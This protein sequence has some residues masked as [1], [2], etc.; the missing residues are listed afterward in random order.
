MTEVIVDLSDIGKDVFEKL[1]IVSTPKL[2]NDPERDLLQAALN[3][4]AAMFSELAE[5][6]GTRYRIFDWA[7]SRPEIV[8]EIAE[9][10]KIAYVIFTDTPGDIFDIADIVAACMLGYLKLKHLTLPE[11]PALEVWATEHGLML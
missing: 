3:V 5:P 9:I 10:N 11:N 4:S 7:S 2:E 1:S 8:A 6:A